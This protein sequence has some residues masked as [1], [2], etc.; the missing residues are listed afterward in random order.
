MNKNTAIILSILAV[1]II[2]I[3]AF[4]VMQKPI[5]TDETPSTSVPTGTVQK[6][7]VPGV[8]TGG[9]AV[10]YTTTVVLTGNVNPNGAATTYWYEYGTTTE[11]GNNSTSQSVGSGSGS[12]YAPAYITGLSSNTTYYYRL[13]A[14]N[15]NGTVTGSTHSFTTSNI[16]PPQGI[17]PSVQTTSATDISRT[18]ADLNGQVT[19][20]GSETRIWFEY[21]TTTELGGITPVQLIGSQDSSI[22]VSASLRDLRPLTTYYFRLNAQNAYGTVNG[23]MLSFTTSGP[24]AQSEPMVNTTAATNITDS[25]AKLNGRVNP[26]GAV[27]TY[28]FEYSEDSLLGSLIGSSTETQTS[29]GSSFV[30]V[31]ADISDLRSNAEYFFRLVGRNDEGTTRGEIKF[32]TTRE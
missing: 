10:P 3:G 25:S 18:T 1:A 23:S 21:G 16:P 30:T 11:L 26:N 28:W 31:S 24:E 20:N 27:T 13:S 9:T 7:G 15:R 5:P 4:L 14:S 17:V 12:V 8:E 6:S 29:S 2:G 19:P 32:F 22:N